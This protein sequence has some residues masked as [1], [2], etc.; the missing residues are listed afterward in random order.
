MTLVQ[1]ASKATIFIL[2]SLIFFMNLSCSTFMVQSHA[3]ELLKAKNDFVKSNE[4]EK[5]NFKENIKKWINDLGSKHTPTVSEARANL[6]GNMDESISF[7]I[8]ALVHDNRDISIESRNI[9]RYV[10]RTRAM[11]DLVQERKNAKGRKLSIVNYL[12]SAINKDFSNA[13][14]ERD[15]LQR[16]L[17]LEE[18][19]NI[20]AT[21]EERR[22]Q[23]LIPFGLDAVRFL[24]LELKCFKKNYSKA[25]I[26]KTIKEVLEKI[27]ENNQAMEST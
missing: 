10:F 25:G 22:W 24:E 7:L 14:K 11:D 18:Y 27:K 16:E 21:I 3:S 2:A 12:I 1:E 6:I 13:K 23:D 4:S 26:H 15:K 5:E 8:L 20:S 17:N 19:L 9:I